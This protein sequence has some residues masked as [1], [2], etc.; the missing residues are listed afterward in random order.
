MP[1]SAAEA[2]KSVV[3]AKVVPEVSAAEVVKSE[4]PA[5]VAPEAEAE[6]TFQCKK[7]GM[8]KPCSQ[9]HIRRACSFDSD[10]QQAQLDCKDCHNL[11]QRCQ[12]LKDKGLDM[13]SISDLGM[14]DKQEMYKKGRD[15]AGKALHTLIVETITVHRT[16]SSITLWEANDSFMDEDDLKVAFKDKPEQMRH[17]MENATQKFC[18]K[19]GVTLY[20]VPDYNKKETEQDQ[21]VESR[22]RMLES[23]F[24]VKNAARPTQ[25]RAKKTEADKLEVKVGGSAGE[26]E[27]DKTKPVTGG[28]IESIGKANEK[29]QEI[30]V[31]LESA[32]LEARAS[33]IVQDI[34]A[35]TLEKG[36]KLLLL[37]TEVATAVDKITKDKR[38]SPDQVKKLATDTTQCKSEGMNTA[39]M[40]RMLISSLQ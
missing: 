21:L 38:A 2:V 34:P 39:K 6:E 18:N 13:T 19:R 11:H 9:K 36:D 27:E 5:K 14:K 15:L 4:V 7:C 25:K 26:G 12:R 40:L 16:I 3:P 1:A 17:I 24:Q 37:F 23:E 22:K 29:L 8:D 31:D 30:R 28:K 32:L 33:D 35:K 10:N 20:G